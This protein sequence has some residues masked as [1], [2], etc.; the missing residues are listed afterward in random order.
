[1]IFAIAGSSGNL[2]RSD[3][4]LDHDAHDSVHG[5]TRL[6]GEEEGLAGLIGGQKRNGVS[7]KRRQLGQRANVTRLEQ[8]VLVGNEL[9]LSE[10]GKL[11]STPQ[12][13]WR[14][15]RAFMA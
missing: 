6:I 5:N 9:V 13:K 7:Q 4:R 12:R 15:A 10:G 14:D 3:C 1:M 8:V 11:H 2:E